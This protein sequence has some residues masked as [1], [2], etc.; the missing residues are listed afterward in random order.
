M[1]NCT[2]CKHEFA[3]SKYRIYVD[4]ITDSRNKNV[5]CP[6]CNSHQIK[7]TATDK[8]PDVSIGRFNS[9]SNEEKRS[10]L[11]KR[12]ST[13]F[14]KEIKEKKEFMNRNILPS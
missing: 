12:S 6:K 7:V 14:Q 1:L 11:K 8:M 2:D 9:M 4:R 10:L 13:H 5:C 3:I